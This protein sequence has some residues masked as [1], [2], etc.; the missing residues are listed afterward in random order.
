MRGEDLRR[1]PCSKL[2]GDSPPRAWGGHLDI[3][4]DVMRKRLTPTCVGRTAA[5]DACAG[6]R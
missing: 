6:R 1:T 2:G 3:W 4:I 5:G